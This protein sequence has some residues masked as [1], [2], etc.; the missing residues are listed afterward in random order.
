[1]T[2]QQGQN[3]STGDEALDCFLAT[4]MS[5]MD[6]CMKRLEDIEALLAAEKN[7][8]SGAFCVC[9]DNDV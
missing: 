9:S 6:N 2:E 1:M 8:H 7:M 4:Y 5:F 3:L